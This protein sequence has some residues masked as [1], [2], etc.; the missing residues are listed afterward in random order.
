ML[1]EYAVFIFKRKEYDPMERLGLNELRENYLQFFESKD[2]LRHPGFSLIPK[3]DKS[4]LLINAG[5]APLK[6]YF[7]GELVPPSVR[8]TTCQKC[9]RTPDIE[10][11]GKT[12]R[13]GTYFEMLGNF[14]FGDYF[15][16]E[17]IA[18]AWEFFTQILRMPAEKLHA[19]VYFEDDE[20][21]AIWR[22]DIGLPTDHISRLG[23]EDNFWELGAGPCG[24]CSEIYFDRGEAYGCGSDDCKVGCD[25]DRFVELWN[26]VFTQFESDGAGNYSNLEK[27]NIDTGMGLERLA[28]VMQGVDNLFEVDTVRRIMEHVSRIADIRYHD[29][30]KQDISLRVITDHIRSTTFLIGD[31]VM[32]SNEGRGYVLRR[33]LRRAARHGRLLGIQRPFLGEVCQT[34]IDENA[35]SYPELKEKKDFI[36]KVIEVEEENFSRTIDA[37]LRLLGQMIEESDGSLLSG[38]D[39]FKL[40]DTF[41]FPIDLTKEILAEKGMSVDEKEFLELVSQQRERARNAR[42]N[43]GADGWKDSDVALSGIKPTEFVGYNALSCD[44]EIQA[45]LVDGEPRE[46]LEPE[47]AG[48]LVLDTT[49]F[50]GESGGQAGD[51][52]TIAFDDCVFEVTTTVRTNAGVILH[53]GVLGGS[54]SARLGQT[55]IAW[56]DEEKRIATQRHHT[57]AHLLQAA[58]RK[59]LGTHVTQ[60]G[61]YVDSKIMR[62]DFTHFS[63]LTEEELL[64]VERLMNVEILACRPVSAE[65]MSIEEA[66]EAGAMALFGEKYADTVRVVKTGDF[67]MELCG[68][69]HTDNTGQ[70][71]LFKILSETSVAAGIRR[72]EGISGME[73]AEHIRKTDILMKRTALVLKSG[74]TGEIARKAEQ[75][76]AQLKQ[77]EK[78]IEQ[79]NAKLSAI[80]AQSMVTAGKDIGAVRLFTGVADIAGPDELRTMADNLRDMADN[81]VAVIAGVN[82]S[83]GTLNFV[84]ACTPAAVKAGAHAGN[85]VRAVA[86]VAGGSGGGRPDNAMAGAKDI[87]KA[88]EAIAAAE[89]IISAMIP[90]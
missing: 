88:E 66:K 32:P 29:N 38:A 18:W 44:A 77:Q 12:S 84:V 72:V 87:A 83:K 2:H 15:K 43:A 36:L 42:L 70:L 47:T 1:A 14:S 67:S 11:V 74:N 45:I 62:F 31:G 7:T 65:E 52:G 81:A 34:V 61:Q 16:K 48:T 33:L 53:H 51:S 20:A 82:K 9:I 19:S 78:D 63:A 58:L 41:G 89:S 5:M 85:I 71:G 26:L 59:V 57:A 64:R 35:S 39:A 54:E 10:R 22:K 73:L 79:L 24:P 80:K 25:C 27:R 28:C 40:S 6:K 13:H 55:V 90:S 4:L 30:E 3:D 50:Y 23:K 17:A 46:Y 76:S 37:G 21:Y 49:P 75:M 8:M 68:G 86:A 69:T 60:A 56:V